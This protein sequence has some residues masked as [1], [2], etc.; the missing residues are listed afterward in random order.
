MTLSSKLILTVGLALAVM[1]STSMVHPAQAAAAAAASLEDEVVVDYE[2]YRSPPIWTGAKSKRDDP[3]LPVPIQFRAGGARGGDSS[4]HHMAPRRNQPPQKRAVI[5]NK[6]PHLSLNDDLKARKASAAVVSAAQVDSNVPALQLHPRG[7]RRGD[8]RRPLGKR[9][10]EEEEED[11]QDEEVDDLESDNFFRISA[12]GDINIDLEE[13]EVN[14]GVEALFEHIQGDDEIQDD[15]EIDEYGEEDE[16]EEGDEE[17]D[18][19]EEDEEQDEDELDEERR[20]DNEAGLQD[21]IEEMKSEEY[22]DLT[23]H[24]DGDKDLFENDHEVQSYDEDE[25]SPSEEELF[26]ASWGH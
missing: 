19:E 9:S 23:G 4:R 20:L 2:K 10:D 5:Y 22:F 18:E 7:G 3:E 6:N 25:P 1:T 26:A 12:D 16:N 17:D 24:P 13:P 15:E 14:G 21:W 11:E 8:V